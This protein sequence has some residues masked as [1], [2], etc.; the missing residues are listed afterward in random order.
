MGH[1]LCWRHRV[2]L[3]RVDWGR[4]PESWKGRPVEFEAMWLRPARHARYALT[5]EVRLDRPL[6]ALPGSESS[7]ITVTPH[8]AA[9]FFYAITLKLIPFFVFV[10]ALRGAKPRYI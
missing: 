1:R 9:I 8:V 4:T 3:A 10:V 7:L 5:V 2:S 6:T